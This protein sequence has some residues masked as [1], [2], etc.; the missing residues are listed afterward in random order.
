MEIQWNIKEDLNASKLK[1]YI[2]ILKDKT[3]PYYS[4]KYLEID[5]WRR[6]VTTERNKILMHRGNTHF[7]KH[8]DIETKRE[9]ENEVAIS[10]STSQVTLYMY[11]L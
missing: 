9:E 1:S 2:K 8:W 6:T 7:L 3:V 5:V 4:T 11:R 10:V